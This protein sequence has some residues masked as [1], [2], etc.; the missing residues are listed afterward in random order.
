MA[1][2]TISSKPSIG[3]LYWTAF[4]E[5]EGDS[6]PAD[7]LRFD[8]YTRRLGNILLPGITNR[9]ERVRYL[10]MVCAGLVATQRPGS[11]VRESR[12][13]FLS[14]ERGWALAMTLAAGG[15]LKLGGQQVGAGRGLKPEFRGLRGANRVLRR[16]RELEGVDA[17]KPSAYVLLQGQDAQGGLGAYLVTLREFGFVHPETLAVT[18]LGRA[19]AEAFAPTGTRGIRL[20]MFCDERAV[21]RQHLV[22]LGEHTTLGRPSAAERAIVRDAIFESPRSIVGEVIRRI[23]A[24]DPN[25]GTAERRLAAIARAGGDPLERAAAFA[26]AFDPMRIAALEVFSALGAALVPR[27]GAATVA[28]LDL[29]TVELDAATLRE[30]ASA[31]TSV[32]TPAG[33][34]PVAA[35]ALACADARTLDETVRALVAYHRREQR[36]WIVAEGKDRYRLGRHG[37]FDPPEDRF[38]DYTL[39]R[40]YQLHDDAKEPA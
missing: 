17:I 30:L 20:D 38:N 25:A 39:G 32:P 2:T 28:E 35:L 37:A 9:T 1:T 34:E 18:T 33:L 16:Y 4:A 21:S 24:A 8:M 29:D 11:S 6:G 12:K 19:L 27:S 10:S 26:L 40:A 14:F 31:V 15:K 5:L 23:D 7:P 13:A 22:R 36:S 3:R